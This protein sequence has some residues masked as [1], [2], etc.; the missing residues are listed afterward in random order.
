MEDKQL[1][2]NLGLIIIGVI[3]RLIPHP[4]N[5]TAITGIAIFS[6]NIFIPLLS[7]FISDIIIGFDNLEIRTTVYGS[8]ALAA[9]IGKFVRKN[10][11]FMNIA[12]G[13]LTASVLFFIITNF[14]VW[15]F[16]GLYPKDLG[17]LATSYILALPFFKNALLGDFFYTGTLFGVMKFWS[18]FKI[19]G[20]SAL[21][22]RV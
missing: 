18:S 15:K 11:K 5:F 22:Q 19:F 8:V 4:A 21:K 17:G 10:P 3:S 13:T 20:L 6:G 14:A 9:L 2:K 12:Y 7:M 1:V 16:G